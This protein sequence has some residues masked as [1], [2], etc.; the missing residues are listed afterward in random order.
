MPKSL[1]ALFFVLI[2]VLAF[3][4]QPATKRYPIEV[5]TKFWGPMFSYDRQPISDPLALQIPI[6]QLQDPEASREFLAYKSMRQTRQWMQLLPAALSIYTLLNRDKVSDGFYW[7]SF[8][9]S[10]VANVYIG[11]RANRHL[12]KSL[13]RYNAVVMGLSVQNTPASPAL[14]LTWQHSF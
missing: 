10:V 3:G 11:V 4:Q 7:G 12:G 6:L 8:G 5:S 9:A 14:G 1:L 13:M 2:G